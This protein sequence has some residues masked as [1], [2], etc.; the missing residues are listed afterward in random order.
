M[1]YSQQKSRFVSVLTLYSMFVAPV[2]YCYEFKTFAAQGLM[3]SRAMCM[4]GVATGKSLG[5][6]VASGIVNKLVSSGT[7]LWDAQSGIQRELAVSVTLWLGSLVA[8]S[9]WGVIN[10]K[11]A[12]AF[13]PEYFEDGYSAQFWREYFVTDDPSK[14]GRIVRYKWLAERVLA[15]GLSLPV[16]HAARAGLMPKL[17]AIDLLAPTCVALGFMGACSGIAGFAGYKR[18]GWHNFLRDGVDVAELVPLSE[19]N[20]NRCSAAICAHNIGLF[21]S[22]VATI[23]LCSWV[24]RQRS[25]LAGTC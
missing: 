11:I 14:A 18:A 6:A 2:A 24:I 21:S 9:V 10:D 15:G 7:H 13:Y 16:I 25:L 1:V 5:N 4:R 17:N 12:Q 19:E 23:G 22:A 8:A 20:H 3:G